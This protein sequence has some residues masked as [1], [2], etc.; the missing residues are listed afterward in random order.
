MSTYP[1]KRI[2]DQ[3][4]FSKPLKEILDSVEHG[5]AIKV[6]SPLEAHTDRQR[7][8]YKGVCIKGLSDWSGDTPSEWDLRLKAQC[9]GTELLKKEIIYMGVGSSCTRLTIRGVGK[10]N[11]TAY[12]ENILSKAIEMDWPVTPPDPELRSKK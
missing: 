12:I 8:W 7:R 1:C 5:G 6:L 2:G 10:R 9:G 3:I 4:T 11:L